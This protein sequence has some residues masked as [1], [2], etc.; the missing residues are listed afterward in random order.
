MSKTVRTR[1]GHGVAYQHQTAAR[2]HSPE[3]RRA[4]LDRPVVTYTT[5]RLK[6]RVAKLRAQARNLCGSAKRDAEMRIADIDAEIAR[7]VGQ[8]LV[9]DHAFRRFVERVMGL[10]YAEICEAM[11]PESAEAAVRMSGKSGTSIRTDRCILHCIDGRVA[12]VEPLP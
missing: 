4:D 5:L 8:S 6:E 12:T 10:N 7:R 11:V 1:K 9:T 3:T 2:D